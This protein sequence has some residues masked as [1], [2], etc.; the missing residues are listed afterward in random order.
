MA[1]GRVS[2]TRVAS[3]VASGRQG[4]GF[5]KFTIAIS[6]RLTGPTYTSPVSDGKRIFGI[7]R[8]GELVVFKAS[9]EFTELGRFQFDEGTH[10]TPAIAHGSLF[11]RTFT[12]LLRIGG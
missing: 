11:V 7:S 1:F 5:T 8:K 10:A 2:T 6:E 4:P 9:P 12:R 3:A